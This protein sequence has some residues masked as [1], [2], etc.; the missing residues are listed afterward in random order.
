MTTATAPGI[1][2]TAIISDQAVLAPD[3]TVGPFCIVEGP[4]E[5]GA[6]CRLFS[7]VVVQ[8]PARIGPNTQI[9]PGACIGLGPQ[10]VKFS[11]GDATGGVE[12][13]NDCIL[14]ENVTIHAATNPDTPTRLGPHAF[15][16]VGS[17]IGH[18]SQIGER[19]TFMNNVLIAGHVQVGDR[20]V[21]A[22]ASVLHQFTRMGRLAMLSGLC[23]TSMDLPPF[24][25]LVDRNRMGGVNLVGMRRAG[26]PRDEITAVRQ[27]FAKVFKPC[28]PRKEMIE[29]LT[30]RG[31]QSPAVAEMAQFVI[32]GDDKRGI[33]AG[34]GRPSPL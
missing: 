13:G 2:P 29:M 6:G 33:C 26:I 22:G 4:V 12:V 14:R 27:A 11:P 20:A 1:H 19:V 28:L 5:I 3:V 18:D 7:H 32:E 10:D 17:H 16:M 34:M 25:L 9:Y 8:G 24:C 23:G 15:L 31:K 21:L 30:E